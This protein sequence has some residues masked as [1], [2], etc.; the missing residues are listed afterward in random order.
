MVNT[1]KENIPQLFDKLFKIL[2]GSRFINREGLG[3]NKPIFIQP[4]EIA[5]QVTVDEQVQS[6]VKRLNAASIPVLSIDLYELCLEVL[7][8]Q[9]PLDIIIENQKYYSSKDFKRSLIGPLSASNTIIPRI[10]NKMSESEH[11]IVFIYGIDKAYLMLSIVPL[12]VDIQALLGNEPFIFFYPGLYDN[13]SLKLFGLINE[14]S[15][16]R[17]RNLN[18]YN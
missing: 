1:K 13:F 14:E 2:S 8:A 5:Q 7:K 17:A 4:Y 10:Q 9:G 6:L 11:K 18:N 3:G 16:Y 15:E 12:L